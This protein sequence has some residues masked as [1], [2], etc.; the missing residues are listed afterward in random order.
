MDVLGFLLKKIISRLFFP[1]G[2]VLGLGL[3]GGL[4]AWRRPRSRAGPRLLMTAWLLLFLLAWPPVS[5]WLMASLEASAGP[6]ADPAR[7]AALGVRQV[8]VL[9]GGVGQGELTPADR[10]NDASLKRLLEGVRL[11]RAL[12]GAR[13]IVSGG[14]FSQAVGV[15]R[16]MYDLAR[17]LG[18]PEAALTLEEQ[19]WDTADEARVLALQLGREPFALVTSAFHMRRS[20]A[21]FRAW[22][23][24][25]VPAPADFRARGLPRDHQA[26]L[27]NAG[28]LWG[29]EVAFYEHLGWWWLGLKNLVGL[30]PGP[31]A[32]GAGG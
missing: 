11:W 25:P 7:L 32:A 20:L 3:A 13:L 1:V 28:A 4:L 5:H 12:P 10:L 19:S 21:Y 29:A 17:D 23:L 16:A 30:G 27:P 14:D 8:V 22:G 24:H 18:V 2:L 26:W 6:Y 31:G 9:G 15:G